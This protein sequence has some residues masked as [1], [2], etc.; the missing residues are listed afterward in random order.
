MSRIVVPAGFSSA[1]EAKRFDVVLF[2]DLS[3]L[4]RDNYL[5]LSL[6]AELHFNGVR[7]VSVA[8]GLDTGDEEAKLEI[9]I[10]GIL[11]S[12]SSRISRR[13]LSRDRSETAGL[14]EKILQQHEW[15]RGELP[16]LSLGGLAITP[17]RIGSGVPQGAQ[18]FREWGW[19]V[20]RGSG[21]SRSARSRFSSLT[22]RRPEPVQLPATKCITFPQQENRGNGGG[23]G[24]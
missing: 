1:G 4:A 5:M 13:R 16:A 9:Q 23:G 3:R 17:P 22:G 18:Y 19:P 14:D 7:V 12:C 11:M 6:M 2:D 15:R 21:L 8:D 10:R 20:R 24:S